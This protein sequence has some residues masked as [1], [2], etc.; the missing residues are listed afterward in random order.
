MT[1]AQSMT[2]PEDRVSFLHRL[3]YGSGAFANNLLA[4]AIVGMIVLLNEN[5]GVSLVMLGVITALP[6]LFDAVTDPI[7]GYISDNFKSRWG[8]RRPFIFVGAILVG[9]SF[10]A[11]WQFPDGMEPGFYVWWYTIGSIVFFLA[12]TIYATPWVALG[13]ELTP[14]YDQ[15]TLLMGTQNFIGQLAFFLPPFMLV[16]AKQ[17]EWFDN[18]IDGARLVALGVGVVVIVCGTIPAIFLR[19]RLAEVAAEENKPKP[20]LLA[21]I[22]GFLSSMGQALS[23]VP[24]LKVCFITFLVFNGFILIASYIYW[25]LSY[26]VYAGNTEAGAEMAALVASVGT[27][28]T[29]GVV[30][31]VTWLASRIGQKRTFVIAIGLAIL[32]YAMKT[33]AYNPDYPWLI[34]IP[35]PLMAFGLGSLFTLMPSMMADIVDQDEL[36]TGQRR[37]GMFASIFWWVVKLG[38]SVAAM[39]GAWLL[40][41]TGLDASLG[42][43]QSDATL[44]MLRVY[45]IGLPI[46]LYGLAIGIV[47]T[48]NVSREK[49]AAVRAQLEERR[50]T[51]DAIPAE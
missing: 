8:R 25:V 45:D 14:D 13:Y 50:G 15:R 16:I 48:L 42:G 49:S 39:A 35:A 26:Y 37:E 7:V 41:S 17:S 22:R 27:F 18:P 43:D 10:F 23:F 3:A 29:F 19:E 4:G 20:S 51:P 46:L 5:L 34:L 21:E 33:F 31:F 12:Y 32:G 30:A 36:R 1:E 2:R 11:L 40:A 47:L 44:L 38:Q 24:F 9:I 6:R 28:S